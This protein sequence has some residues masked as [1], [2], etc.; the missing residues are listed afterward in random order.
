MLPALTGLALAVGA[1][2][3]SKSQQ[4]D[5]GQVGTGMGAAGTSFPIGTYTNCAR[6][7]GA[8]APS[9]N[10]FL[11]GAGFE[12]GSVLTLA[13]SGT[14]VQATYVDWNGL[15]Q[16]VSF[17]TTTG[18]SATLTQAGQVLPGFTSL[19]VE[20]P[21]DEAPYPASM[22][23]RAGA[24]IYSAGM[25]FITLTGGLQ[26]DAGPCGTLSAPEASLW[27]LCEDRQG[28]ALPS[29]DE[30]S[31]PVT[32]L[33]AGQYSCRSQVENLAHIDG[34]DT[35]V[36]GGGSGTLTLAQDGAKVTAQ[37]AGDSSLAGTLSLGVTTSTTATAEAGQT[38]MAPCMVPLGT[39]TGTPEP[40]PSPPGRS[41]SATQRSFSPSRVPWPPAPRVPAR[42][43]P[44]A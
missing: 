44:G 31:P 11:N 37:Y 33:P 17:S 2:C 16:S 36:T 15:T 34:I 9:G 7:A 38:L 8:R 41:L 28:G 13:Q 26:S 23:T 40:Y 39:G 21:G 35:F 18:T 19:C 27:I 1:G 12:S 3:G 5:G 22:T 25:V 14:T 10:L 43:W 24:M 42:K 4:G 20:G 6:G 29:T 30:G 32:P